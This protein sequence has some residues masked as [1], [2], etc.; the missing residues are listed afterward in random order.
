MITNTALIATYNCSQWTA[1]KVDKQVTDEVTAQHGASKNSGKWDKLLANKRYMTPVQKIVNEARTYHY[2]N[3]LVWG[4][5]GQ[6]LLPAANYF[7][8]VQKMNEFKQRFE[9]AVYGLLDTLD[10]VKEVAKEELNGMYKESDY[11]S[12][13][14]LESKFNFRITMM[15]VP[16]SDFRVQLGATELAQLKAAAEQEITDRMTA[17]VA[18]VWKRI[19]KALKHMKEKL[20]E[21]RIDK[22]GKAKAQI[23]RDSLFDNIGDLVALLPK[24]NVTNDPNIDSV[25]AEM[26]SLI[27]DP[28]SVRRDALLRKRKAEE[29]DV[30]LNKFK[31]FM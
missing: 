5:K 6:G 22:D 8:Y 20:T 12:R 15:P 28:N 21:D 27:T 17:A 19:E 30:V 2:E 25:C 24:L 31:A 14:E 11:P 29:V 3:T 13:E 10:T 9:T 7:D 4:L 16:E 26:S 23:Y 18:D 1:R